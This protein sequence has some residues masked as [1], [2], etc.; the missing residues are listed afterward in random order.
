MSI[1]ING[2]LLVQVL[3]ERFLGAGNLDRNN[4]VPSLRPIWSLAKRNL[5]LSLQVFIAFLNE[6]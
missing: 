5:R 2:L 3:G 4:L 1:R 6:K